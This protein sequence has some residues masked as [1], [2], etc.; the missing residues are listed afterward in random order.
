MSL[1]LRLI[2]LTSLTC[3]AVIEVKKRGYKR[4]YVD[5]TKWNPNADKAFPSKK[6]HLY[7]NYVYLQCKNRSMFLN[8]VVVGEEKKFKK[9][10]K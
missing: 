1:I 7:S 4:V 8:F 9:W 3:D 6:I 2:L 10:S 5:E